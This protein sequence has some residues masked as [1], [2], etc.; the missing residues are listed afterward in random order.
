MLREILM[1]EPGTE[2]ERHAQRRLREMHDLFDLFA[3]WY[4]DVQ[5][6]ETER[7]IQLLTLAPR[8]RRSWT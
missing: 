1:Q 6:L 8:S 2:E 4:S 5:R 7:L 3:G